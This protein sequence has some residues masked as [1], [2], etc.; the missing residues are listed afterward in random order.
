MPLRRAPRRVV[1]AAVGRGRGR[2]VESAPRFKVRL[3]EKK[4]AARD[5]RGARRVL[6]FASTATVA[7]RGPGR[8]ARAAAV[9]SPRHRARAE[10]LGVRGA[11]RRRSPVDEP[12][13][14][15]AHRELQQA[16]R[17]RRGLGAH[18]A[19]ARAFTLRPAYLSFPE[20]VL[21]PAAAGDRRQ[22]GPA[23][24]AGDGVHRL[25]ALRPPGD[26]HAHREPVLAAAAAP[27]RLRHARAG[28]ARGGERGDARSPDAIGVDDA[29]A[30]SFFFF[31]RLV[32][33]L[34][35]TS[36]KFGPSA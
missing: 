6:Q 35:F 33:L 8:V 30:R 16:P 7:P 32:S 25:G 13:P 26:R 17:L 4:A 10:Q 2:R 31:L 5:R 27:D 3:H 11:V 14:P 28:R 9:S 15:D 18:R 22:D 36:S 23:D 24:G 1:F 34:V 29:L 19:D 21:V 12:R 20:L